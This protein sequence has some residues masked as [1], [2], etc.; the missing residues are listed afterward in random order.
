[1]L[2]ARAMSSARCSIQWPNCDLIGSPACAHTTRR[3]ARRALGAGLPLH[4]TKAA[5]RVA[6]A[7]IASLDATE[8]DAETQAG[9]P[10][11]QLRMSGGV[12]TGKPHLRNKE[13]APPRPAGRI[14]GDATR[15]PPCRVAKMCH[16]S[17]HTHPPWRPPGTRPRHSRRAPPSRPPPWRLPCSPALRISQTYPSCI[18]WHL[19]N[20]AAPPDASHAASTLPLEPQATRCT[21]SISAGRRAASPPALRCLSTTRPANRPWR[22]ICC[23]DISCRVPPTCRVAATAVWWARLDAQGRGRGEQQAAAGMS[24]PWP[25]W[26]DR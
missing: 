21:A 9:P 3:W 4:A 2:C 11:A 8:T 18:H 19:T 12:K 23:A 20:P 24:V 26:Q 1:M 14:V 22:W 17:P 5:E 13:E 7:A 25:G 16:A 10:G 6:A 15:L